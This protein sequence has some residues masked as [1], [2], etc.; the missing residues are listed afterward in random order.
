MAGLL[1]AD[2][3]LSIGSMVGVY[4]KFSGLLDSEMSWPRRSSGFN[5]IM[6]PFTAILP[7]YLLEL[8]FTLFLSIINFS[9]WLMIFLYRPCQEK[10]VGDWILACLD[11]LPMG[12]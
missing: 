4:V 5:V 2:V 9:I 12:K 3:L 8:W 6:Y 11:R 1:I 10:S 7:F